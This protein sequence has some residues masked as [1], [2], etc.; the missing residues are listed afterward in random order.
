MNVAVPLADLGVP[1]A[2]Y[3]TGLQVT[4]VHRASDGG[5][6]GA[7]DFLWWHGP[8]PRRA[9][10][11]RMAAQHAPLVPDLG[12][13]EAAALL[14]TG[15]PH[16][17]GLLHRA[18]GSASAAAWLRDPRPQAGRLVA[19]SLAAAARALRVLHGV[20]LPPGPQALPPPGVRRLQKWAA[21][22]GP[23]VP[24]AAR[25]RRRAGEVWGEGRT[26]RLLGWADDAVRPS[27]SGAT[28]VPLHGWA[29]TGSLVP[30]RSRGRVAL[31]TGED[32][33]AGRRELDLGWM[34]GDLVELAWSSPLHRAAGESAGLLSVRDL[35]RVFLGA[36]K[37][38]E[39]EG[40]DQG[41]AG[42][43][44]DPVAVGR[45]AVLR[46]VTHMQDFAT[47]CEWSD[48]LLDYLAF[49]AELIDEEGRRAV[50][51]GVS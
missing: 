39:S 51:R 44:Y 11:L 40:G 29:S 15:T 38:G 2:E 25:L 47:Y 41:P 3:G 9:G 27:G 20:P 42:P 35:Q 23:L 6:G 1:V 22:S 37:A 48:E 19:H 18:A 32:L 7:G 30:P 13:V 31:L 36:Y 8:G 46:V 14:A 5:P 50:P 21:G 17:D 28:V 33:G 26:E 45:C 12:P 4:R 34:L 10:P 16:G 43:V 24:A 49:T